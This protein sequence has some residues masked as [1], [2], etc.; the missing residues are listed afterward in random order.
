MQIQ[1]SENLTVFSFPYALFVLFDRDW[2]LANGYST[3]SVWIFPDLTLLFHPSKW[4][5]SSIIDIIKPQVKK[6]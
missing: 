5:Q 6:T 2:S 4:N 3:A 1:T